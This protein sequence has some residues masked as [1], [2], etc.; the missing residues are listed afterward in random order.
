MPTFEELALLKSSVERSIGNWE[1][2]LQVMQ[3]QAQ[4]TFDAGKSIFVRNDA[5]ANSP[6]GP[7]GPRIEGV[8]NWLDKARDAV[9]SRMPVSAFGGFRR[10]QERG[11]VRG[12]CKGDQV[13]SE[14]CEGNVFG[15]SGNRNGKNFGSGLFLHRA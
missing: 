5:W 7:A 8:Q 11:E 3:A 10:L 4:S 6:M 2:S 15:A 13:V 14:K 1:K 9:E 12:I